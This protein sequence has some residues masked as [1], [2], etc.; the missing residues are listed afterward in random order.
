MNVIVVGCGRVGAELADRLYSHGHQVAVVDRAADAFHNLPLDFRGRTLEGDVL[1]EAVLHRAGI[2]EADGL[3]AVT[4]NDS[5]NAVVGH[6]ARKMYRVANVVVRNYDPRW[7][8]L[9][10]A[11]H[12][13]PVS[14]SS[15]GAQQMEALLSPATVDRVLMVGE[16]EVSVYEIVIPL[17]WRGRALRDLLPEAGC[18]VV[19]LT[20]AGSASLPAPRARLEL[21]D[22]VHVGA[23]PDGIAALRQRLAE[24]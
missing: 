5:L 17:P 3:A 2:E 9:I 8:P 23:T 24:E 11:F 20:R 19:A 12:L 6:L 16:G 14:S 21:G 4:A 18:L 1:A 10:D 22:I 7:R 13:L 15:W